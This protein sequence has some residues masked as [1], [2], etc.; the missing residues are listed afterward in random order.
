MAKFTAPLSVTQTGRLKGFMGTHA[1]VFKGIFKTMGAAA[2]AAVSPWIEEVLLDPQA[3]ARLHTD[4]YL[5]QQCLLSEIVGGLIRGIK[6]WSKE[7]QDPAKALVLRILARVLATAELET[8]GAWAASLRFAVFDRHPARVAWLTTYLFDNALPI[9]PETAANSVIMSRR[10]LLLRPILNELSWRGECLQRQLIH[11]LEPFLAH[12]LAQTRGCVASCIATIAR[13][14][15]TPPWP[16]ESRPSSEE[17]RP[18]AAKSRDISAASEADGKAVADAAAEAVA[19]GHAA[20]DAQS[21]AVRFTLAAPQLPSETMHRIVTVMTT[22]LTSLSCQIS[23]VKRREK[24]ASAAKKE[25]AEKSSS[26]GKAPDKEAGVIEAQGVEKDGEKDLGADKDKAI[27]A[28]ALKEKEKEL[29]N[30]RHSLISILSACCPNFEGIYTSPLSSHLPALLPPLLQAME[31]SD[32]DLYAKGCAE[33]S[34]STPLLTDTVLPKVLAAVHAVAESSSWHVRATVLPFLQIILFRHQFAIRPE[35]MQRVRDLMLAL[36]RDPQVEVRETAQ[37]AISV[38]VRIQGEALALQLR[39]EFAE[40]AAAPIPKRAKGGVPEDGSAEAMRK[41]HAGVLGLA[42][43]VGAYPYD[44]PEWMPDVLVQ[45]A[46]HVL[47]PSPINQ[48]VRQAFGEFWRTHQDAWPMLKESFG[49]QH[50]AALTN[51]L[52][53]PT[54]FS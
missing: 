28:E 41:R 48:A 40:W 44:V 26:G 2:L 50:M 27:K 16:E 20:V 22:R 21:K 49:D 32:Q 43:L 52:V 38:L 45:L 35:D 34:A 19:A 42:A 1:Q 14:S 33:L 4:V 53:A 30:M 54:Y 47:D 13:V 36:L 24:A 11:D 15:W 18:P 39:D 31:D 10:I 51:L 37:H 6:Y 8:V 29:K 3:Y 46:G 12:P 17:P 23:E 25:E 7:D 5:G 9:T